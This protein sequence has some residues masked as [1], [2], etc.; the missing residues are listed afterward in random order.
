MSS[1][2]GQTIDI[3]GGVVVRRS[4]GLVTLVGAGPGDPD[5]LTRKGY[6]ALQVAEVVFFDDL[7]SPE[8]VD[9]L[10]DHARCIY[11]G[12][13]HHKAMIAQSDIISQLI[14]AAR[15]GLRVV[16][17]KG[18]DPMVFGRSAEEIDA[19]RGAGIPVEI[20]PGVTAAS[21]S[22]AAMK[23]SLTHR[24]YASRVTFVTATRRAGALADVRGLAG[25]GRTVVIYMGLCKAR[26]LRQVLLA[27]GLDAAW[28]VAVVEHATRPAQRIIVTTVA[29][30][31]DALIR[32]NVQSP[33]LFIVGEVV[34]TYVTEN[35]VSGAVSVASI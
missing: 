25:L 22:A 14:A 7:V 10:P 19:L 6:A 29:D 21:A 31:P 18:G 13:P 26:G 28:P 3:A 32:E 8:I 33:A 34:R 12:K 35:V 16:R 23:I 2:E 11:V 20:I 30:L 5:L 17:L 1:S 27:E 24:E 9:I 15:S 4:V